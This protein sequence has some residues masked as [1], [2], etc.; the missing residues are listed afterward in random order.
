MDEVNSISDLKVKRVCEDET[1]TS[2]SEG[3]SNDFNATSE[4]LTAGHGRVVIVLATTSPS[5]ANL[6]M[7]HHHSSNTVLGKSV[8]A[9]KSAQPSIMT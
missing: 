9:V 7:R 8:A 1:L 4:E 2:Q 3:I 5:T 6:P